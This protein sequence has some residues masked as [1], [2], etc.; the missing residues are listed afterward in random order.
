MDIWEWI[1]YGC[2]QGWCSEPVCATHDGIPDTPDEAG[3]W[4]A[5]ADPCQHV[6][7]LW[8]GDQAPPPPFRK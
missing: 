4:E 3:E 7:R 1:E 6:L 5:G 2:A 8:A